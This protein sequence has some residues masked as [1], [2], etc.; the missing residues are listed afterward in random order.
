LG[1]VVL[2]RCGERGLVVSL[3]WMAEPSDSRLV[4]FRQETDN[5]YKTP[6]SLFGFSFFKTQA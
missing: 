3:T 5:S 1:F 2:G 4:I 6:F